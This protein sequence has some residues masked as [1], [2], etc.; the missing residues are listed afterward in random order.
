MMRIQLSAT[1]GHILGD[2]GPLVS[3]E[4]GRDEEITGKKRNEKTLLFC[5][6]QQFRFH[7]I[8]SSRDV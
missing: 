7:V 3:S 4:L 5:D 8:S 1:R 2:T 6:L